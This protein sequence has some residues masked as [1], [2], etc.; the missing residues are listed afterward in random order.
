MEIF[1]ILFIA[2]GISIATTVLASN[3]GRNAISWFFLS[4]LWGIV[5]L[6]IL[7]CSKTLDR[8]EGETDTLSTTL[9]IITLIPL[10]VLGFLYYKFIYLQR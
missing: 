1:I 8:E 7:A 4:I 9:W 10:V 5:G 3:K 6:V 2:I